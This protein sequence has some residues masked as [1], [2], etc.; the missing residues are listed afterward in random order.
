MVLERDGENG[1]TI[2][3]CSLADSEIYYI[4][5]LASALSAVSVWKAAR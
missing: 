5:L 1:P 4:A 2:T 3:I